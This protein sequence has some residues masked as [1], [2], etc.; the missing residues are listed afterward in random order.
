MARGISGE[1]STLRDTVGD[2][3]MDD[4]NN[5][6]RVNVVAGGAGD[7]A[8][9][10]G[11][12]A[13]IKATVR[14]YANSNPLAVT[15]TDTTGDYIAAGAGTQ[16]TEADTD[17]S[18][19][20]TAIMFE[21]NTGTNAL[22]VVNNTTPL[23]VGDAGGSLT[24]DNAAL[25]VTGGG[26]EATA[27]RVTVASDSTGVLSVDDNGASL[28]VDNAALSVT[29][30]GVEATA[31]RVTVASDSTGVLSVDDN[32]AALTVDNGGTFAVQVDGAALTALQLI[33]DVVHSGD[34]ALSKYAVMGAVLDDAA[35]ATV[36]ENQAQSL[37]MTSGRALHVQ[38][39][40]NSGVDIGDVTINNAAGASAVNVQDGGNAITVDWAGTA[41]PIGAGV[42]A[43][44]LRVTVA[45]DS[46]GVLSVDDNGSSLTIDGTV[47][48]GDGTDTVD[49]LADG[50]DNVANTVN[51]LVTAAMLYAYD[52]T[53]FDR[54]TN[55]GGVEATALRVTVASDSTG[56]LSVDDNGSTLTVD[57]PVGTPVNVQI[58]NATL[59][60]GVID[61]TGAGAVDALAGGGGTAHDAVDSGNPIKLGAKVETSP[62]GI[63]LA[64]DA[65]RTNLYADADGILL[66]KNMTAWGDVVAERVSDTGGT[67]TAFTTFDNAA[68]TRNYITAISVHNAHA[69]TNGYVDIR[70][71]TA[72]A[73]IWTMPA[74]ATG[75]SIIAFDPPLRQPTAATAL[76]YDV[77]AA[78]TTVYVSINGFKSKV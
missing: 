48:I 63:T 9:L 32:G 68:G 74:P 50:A 62:K 35:T 46:T 72:G 19:T 61:E 22:A 70:D 10:D 8:I 75:G 40:A 71:G 65:D 24:I 26:V 17:A 15:L 78:I 29:G 7:G 64:A 47:A 37:R 55:G 73:V 11:V 4:T 3:V 25:S 21:S 20:G 44:A 18:I 39:Q 59:V 43:T 12:S 41:P 67:S 23:P 1:D 36:T 54:V 69:T 52:G 13:S 2:S 66:T 49:V 56:V 76:A 38:A 31:L 5:A 14:D 28:T 57:A 27:V 42:E 33:D 45:T 30:G 60:A 53:A 77:S 51:Q 58:G 34:A 6:V 16:Y